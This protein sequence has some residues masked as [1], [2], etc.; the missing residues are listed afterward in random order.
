MMK[1]AAAFLLCLLLACTASCAPAEAP[2]KDEIPFTTVGDAVTDRAFIYSSSVYYMVLVEKD[3][4]WWRVGAQV[5]D[6]FTELYNS[7]VSSEDISAAYEEMNAYARSL[8]VA[9]AEKL[10][11]GPLSQEVLNGY[12]GKKMKDL[13][14][15]GFGFD[16]SQ[17]FSADESEDFGTAMIFRPSDAAG[18]VYRL[19]FYLVYTD[20]GYT[21]G[22]VFM[23]NKG[24]FAYQFWFKGTEETLK[25]AIENGTWEEMEIMYDPV[26]TGL[27]A[28]VEESIREEA[29]APK[30]PTNEQAAAI[31][32]VH[33]A[34]KYDFIGMYSESGDM[35]S[36]LINGTDCF[37]LATA[38]LDDRYRELSLAAVGPDTEAAEALSDYESSLPV[39]VKALEAPHPPIR[40]LSACVGK[41]VRELQA[42]GFRISTFFA[43][44]ADPSKEAFNTAVY[45]PD[46]DGEEAVITGSVIYTEYTEYLMV[47]A[48]EGYY[49]YTFTFDGTFETLEDAIAGGTFPDLIVRKAVY[50][51]MS[52]CAA[53]E[54]GLR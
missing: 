25:E 41:T 19:P 53:T 54:M 28:D 15:D 48:E 3:G 51:G 7:V 39:T 29:Y 16:W 35:Y 24:L 52:S 30:F 43:S 50:S 21:D 8:P 23:M 36:M 31:R 17:G 22:L 38:E 11:E 42:E 10:G 33:D 2:E 14:A 49:E 18:T 12:T 27:R 44:S 1:K 20:P 5:D 46:A 37:W 45:L 13:L 34:E 47:E 40:D 32:T 9:S 6:R 26:F 4:A